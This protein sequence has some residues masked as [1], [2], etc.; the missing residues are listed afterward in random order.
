MSLYAPGLLDVY[1]F[2]P[3][4]GI[5][6]G[7]TNSNHSLSTG[8]ILFTSDGG[9][10]WTERYATS[11]QG[12]WCWKIS[13]P[14][15]N[16]GYVS[17]QRNVGSPVNIVKTTD[18]GN[19]WAEKQFFATPYYVQGIGFANDTL[20]WIGGNSTQTSYQ[21]TDGGDTW[22]P[23]NFGSRINRFQF[24]NELVGYAGG[25]SVYKYTGRLITSVEETSLPED[26]SLSQNFPNPFNPTTKIR[27]TIP[28]LSPV[29]GGSEN[30]LLYVTLKIYDVLG[31]EVMTVVNE[32]KLP[33][34]NEIEIFAGNLASGVYYYTLQAGNFVETKKMIILK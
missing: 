17:I 11:K 7:L 23:A 27:F 5:A 18:G 32:E 10:T 14:S 20:G 3:D 34:E 31:K 33:G 19:T 29:E 21:T 4:S 12:E 2:T 1:F 9:E 26:F 15:R 13:F 22:T 24:V 28:R 6:V 8:N 25:R 16:T 30:G